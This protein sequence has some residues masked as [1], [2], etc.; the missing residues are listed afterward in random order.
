MQVGTVTHFYNKIGVAVIS[1]KASLSVG[2]KI[3]ISGHDKEFIQ[4]VTSLQN[5]HV[6]I[7]KAGKGDSIGLKVENPVKEGDVI[8]SVAE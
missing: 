1:L 2:D 7:K 3:K 4:D 8:F 5:K 6:Q